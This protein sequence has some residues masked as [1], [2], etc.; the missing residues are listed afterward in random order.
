MSESSRRATALFSFA[1]DLRVRL[2]SLEVP[3]GALKGPVHAPVA[4]LLRAS[5]RGDRSAHGIPAR[6]RGDSGLN[7]LANRTEAELGLSQF[8]LFALHRA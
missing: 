6:R 7:F 5:A 3:S 2:E 1:F 8:C 4:Q